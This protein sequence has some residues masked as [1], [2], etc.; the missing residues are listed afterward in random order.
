M[1][2]HTV[3]VSDPPAVAA[4]ADAAAALGPV[5]RLAHTAGLSPVM[6]SAEQI[7][8]DDLYG[9]ALVLVRAPVA[10]SCDPSV[11][12][13]RSSREVLQNQAAMLNA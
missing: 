1:V 12:T 6:A 2:T 9:T 13:G 8:K 11:R 5:T 7:L 3:D 4:L 10:P